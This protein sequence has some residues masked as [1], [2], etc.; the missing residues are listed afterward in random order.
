[1]SPPHDTPSPGHLDHGGIT[2]RELA[3]LVTAYFDGALPSVE[4]DRFEQHLRDCPPCI[5]HL[6]QIRTT[7]RVTGSVEPWDIDPE[8]RV[9]LLETFRTWHAES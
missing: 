7:I 6:E 4:A 3:D 9:Q 1:M 2:C 8:V 5:V